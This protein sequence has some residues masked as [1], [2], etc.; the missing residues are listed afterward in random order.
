MINAITWFEIPASDLY[1]AREFYETVLHI[2]MR[3]FNHKELE[4]ILFP[5]E[6]GGVGGAICYNPEHYKPGQE[7][8]VIYLNLKIEM[9]LA[10]KQ[11]EKSGGRILKPKVLVSE[12]IGYMAL[13]SDTEGNRVGLLSSN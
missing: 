9:D 8:P 13:I 12:T 2:E 1:R 10:L 5:W 4:M 11:V 6:E 3:S 7:G